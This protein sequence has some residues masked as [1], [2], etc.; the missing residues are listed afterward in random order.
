[1]LQ[2]SPSSHVSIRWYVAHTTSIESHTDESTS[3]WRDEI[4]PFAHEHLCRHCL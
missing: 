1:M 4:A 3:N 2:F